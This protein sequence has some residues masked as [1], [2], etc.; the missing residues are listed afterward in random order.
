MASRTY[1]A[2]LRGIN[3]GGR[4]AIPMPEL[5]ALC[6]ELGHRD[7]VTYLQ[8]GNLVFGSGDDPDAIV[9]G[10]QGSIA[11]RLGLEIS[12]VLRTHPELAA[13]AAG[14]P[15]DQDDPRKLHVLFLSEQPAAAALATL[16][17]DRSPGRRVPRHRKRTSTSTSRT[18]QP[19]RS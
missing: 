15:F 1:A 9:T 17:P 18:A 4:N 8:S 5:R 7:V 2:L 16:D 3:V 6:L 19:G 11:E 13:I 12:V 14:S 10:I